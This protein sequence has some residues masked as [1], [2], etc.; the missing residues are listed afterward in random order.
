VR[1]D[2]VE[3]D[4]DADAGVISQAA[5]AGWWRVSEDDELADSLLTISLL[6][7]SAHRINSDYITNPLHRNT[8]R[9]IHT[10]LAACY[11]TRL[12][13]ILSHTLW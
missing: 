11:Y 2:G 4:I 13:S 9:Y 5:S 3:L 8:L 12:A 7:N 10:E 6:T 1:C